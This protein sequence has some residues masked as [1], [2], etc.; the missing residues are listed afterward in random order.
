MGSSGMAITARSSTP[1]GPSAA[2]R[3]AALRARLQALRGHL[4]LDDLLRVVPFAKGTGAR[5]VC[6]SVA[7]VPFFGG[8]GRFGRSWGMRQSLPT[9]VVP[10]VGAARRA[11]LAVAPSNAMRA[12]C[13]ELAVPLLIVA[14]KTYRKHVLGRTMVPRL[15]RMGGAKGCTQIRLPPNFASLALAGVLRPSGGVSATVFVDACAAKFR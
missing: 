11:W 2:E 14:M 15:W 1:V 12:A 10:R 6:L 13:D 5:S 8:G 4:G 7:S 3:M 9:R